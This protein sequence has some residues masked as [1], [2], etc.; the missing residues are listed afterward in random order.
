MPVRPP[1]ARALA[2]LDPANF[3]AARLKTSYARTLRAATSFT[4]TQ[5]NLT[6]RRMVNARLSL[7]SA[8][9]SPPENSSHI[10]SILAYSDVV[11]RQRLDAR[12]GVAYDRHCV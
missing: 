11:A 12:W 1:S 7:R 3:G 2:T 10:L 9:P 4:E 5:L 8:Q 6:H